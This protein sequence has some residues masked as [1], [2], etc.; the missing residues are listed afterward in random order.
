MYNPTNPLTPLLRMQLEMSRQV[1]GALFSGMETMSHIALAMAQRSAN[2]QL[3]LARRRPGQEGAAKAAGAALPAPPA[4]P[5]EYQK[6]A[7]RIMS[8]M[9]GELVKSMAKSME[10]GSQALTGNRPAPG[11]KEHPQF[12][13]LL[14]NPM[15]NLAGIW[16]SF[17]NNL[18]QAAGGGLQPWVD[19]RWSPIPDRRVSKTRDRRSATARAHH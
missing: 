11:T 18:S 2:E 7:L 15:E 6:E 19:K 14:R 3:A 10:Q 1:A 4:T 16:S 17:A 12:D 8:T 5:L 13:E 9:Q